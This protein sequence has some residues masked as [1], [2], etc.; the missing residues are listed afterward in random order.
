MGKG[1]KYIQTIVLSLFDSNNDIIFNKKIIEKNLL[2]IIEIK[3]VN[4]VAWVVLIFNPPQ[5]SE[6]HLFQ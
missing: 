1:I 3:S 4:K 5:K 2:V 6:M